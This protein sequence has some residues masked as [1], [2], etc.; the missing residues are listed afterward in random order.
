M[1]PMH[2]QGLAAML[3]VLPWAALGQST[4]PIWGAEAEARGYELPR[5]FGVTLSAMHID[6]PLIIDDIKLTDPT[7]VLQQ[8]VAVQGDMAE[9]DSQTYTLRADMWL[10]PFLNLY[11]LVG[12][13]EG[14][15]EAQ[16]D[17]FVAGAPLPVNPIDFPLDFN[18]TTFGGGATLAYG[19]GN[20]FAAIDTNYTFT[21]LNII[22]GEIEAFVAAPRV[23]YRWP[24]GVHEYRL[25]VGAMYQDVDQLFQGSLSNLGLG[26]QLGELLETV[27]PNGRFEVR[28]HLV[29]P[30]NGL[31]GAMYVYD[32]RWE[33]ILEG[34][35][36]DRESV[37]LST[38]YRF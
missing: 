1:K 2:R 11:A 19:I 33:F 31:I 26:G 38:G 17:A 14:T 30:W 25:W 3:A 24:D 8:L 6:Q 28:Q 22:D 9:Q 21:D 15:S 27:A 32:R 35:L 23:G 12:Y 20:W 7:G 10:F 13:T 37:F 29:E 34:G 36:G 18:G 4:F 5:P 16:V